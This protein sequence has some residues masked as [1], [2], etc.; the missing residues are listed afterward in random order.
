MSNLFL[1]VHE[2]TLE[3]KSVE[4]WS[5]IA[6]KKSWKGPTEVRAFI[7]NGK[8]VIAIKGKIQ[9]G[10]GETLIRRAYEA[11]QEKNVVDIIV[12]FGKCPDIDSCGIG[13]VARIIAQTRAAKGRTVFA[14]PNKLIS[15][16]ITVAK[17]GTIAKSADSLKL[18]LNIK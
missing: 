7:K 1:E 17:L 11:L 9:L 2:H 8:G 6:N 10:C 3:P 12:D 13:E 14:R 18:A 5:C 16:F 4:D 15:D